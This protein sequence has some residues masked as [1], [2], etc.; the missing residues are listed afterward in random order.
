[1]SSGGEHKCLARMG[2]KPDSANFLKN[3]NS[4]F[5][6]T[7]L[8]GQEEDRSKEGAKPSLAQKIFLPASA[9]Y[10]SKMLY[11]GASTNNI[12]SETIQ[13]AANSLSGPKSEVEWRSLL[14]WVDGSLSP[15]APNIPAA[16]F[17]WKCGSVPSDAALKTR[18]RSWFPSP[19]SRS[20]IDTRLL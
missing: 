5:Q 8:R 15:P 20:W 11:W 9:L 2:T 13:N 10:S 4:T 1:M 3:L 18:F 12:P 14:S 7:S 16:P 17:P 19:A 6:F